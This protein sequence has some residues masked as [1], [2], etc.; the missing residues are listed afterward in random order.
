MS[1]VNL[2]SSLFL[3]LF[4]FTSLQLAFYVYENLKEKQTEIW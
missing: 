4:C 3:L 1:L 2:G